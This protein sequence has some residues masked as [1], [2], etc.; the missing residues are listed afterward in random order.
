MT[1]DIRSLAILLS[2][3]SLLQV[4]VL[5]VQY[6][7]NR[8]Q[9]GAGWWVVGTFLFALA[10]V[11]NYLR[12]IPPFQA[13]AIVL[14]NLLFY[15]ALSAIYVGVARFFGQKVQV[16]LVLGMGTIFVLVAIYFTVNDNLGVRRVNFS[17][18][19]ALL[20][21]LIGWSLWRCRQR[22]LLL[23][24]RILALVFFANVVFYAVRGLTPFFVDTV[25]EIFTASLTQTASY[26]NGLI[27]STVWTFG[28]IILINQQLNAEINQ[29][30]ANLERIFNTSPDAV[31][32]SRLTDGVLVRVNDG[33]TALCGY[34]RSEAIGKSALEINIWRD[35]A[36]RQRMTELLHATGVCDNLEL[37]FQRKDGSQFTGIVSAKLITLH[38]MP[39]IISVTRDITERK[40]AEDALRKSEEKFRAMA[41]LLPQIIFETD[42]QGRLTYVNRQAYV[43]FG[44]PENV[45]MVGTLSLAFHVPE[46]RDRV[47]ANIQR[48]SRGEPVDDIEYTML[49]RD[50]STFPALVFSTPIV[51]DGK[52][53]GLRGIIVDIT[54]RKQTE[55][56]LRNTNA[57]LENL[58]DYAN[59]PIIVWD[60]RLRITRFNHAFE[61]LTGYRE[62]EMLGR[63]PELLFPPAEV[64]T[65]MAQIRQTS[66]GKRW[67]TVEI[68]ILH[69]NGAVRTVLWNSATVFATDGVTPVAT[70][71]QGQDIT[72]RKQAEDAV[73]AAEARYARAVRGTSDGLW[74]WNIQT[75]AAYYSPRYREL[76]GY[77]SA[78]FVADIGDFYAIVHPDDLAH[79]EAVER[80]H[81]EERVP[82]NVELRMRTQHGDYRWFQSRAQAEWDAEGNALH[83]AG[84]ITDISQ[85][86]RTEA[87]LLVA[88]EQAEAANRAKS[89][90]LAN[91][92]HELRTPLN[93]ILGF[94]ELL[95]RDARLTAEQQHNL[96]IINRSG[97]HL[98]RLINDVL[99]MAKIESG[100][101]SVQEREFDLHRLIGEMGDLF[102]IRAAEK[103]LTLEVTLA[104]GTPAAVVADEGKL[105]QMLINLLGNAFKFT[106][107]GGVALAVTAAADERGAYWLRFAVRDTGPGIPSEDLAAIFEPFVQV[108]HG[109]QVQ[110]GTGLGLPISRQFARLMGGDITVTSAGPPHQGSEFVLE[111]PV[112]T[113]ESDASPPLPS[114][115]PPQRLAP[116]QPAYRL[117]IVEDRAESRKLLGDL[118]TR[119]GFAVCAAENGKQ[120]LRLWSEWQPHL[121]WMDMRMP[122]MDG[123]AAV[124][125]IRAAGDIS[126]IIIAISASVLPEERAAVIAEGCNDFVGKPYREQEIVDCLVRHLGVQMMALPGAEGSSAAVISPLE[127]AG[128]SAAWRGQVAQ[129][130]VAADVAEL[131]RL[132]D[133]AA[134][135]Q[136]QVAA[137]LRNWIN[138]YDYGAI[139]AAVAAN[140]EH[141]YAA[142]ER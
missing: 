42:L 94:S 27:L 82:Y 63:S 96:T 31:V 69:C 74:D 34:T 115:L 49:R 128:M 79:V 125:H 66:T 89:D 132:A 46:E 136:P 64:A 80:A 111:V 32:I 130:A 65:S 18:A 22:P 122:V 97:E 124:R 14:N 23:T 103:G 120:A 78:E 92:S 87:A 59:A 85:R 39:H 29:A 98:L 43:T 51:Q 10:F 52:P 2:L 100:R 44:Y 142:N 127:L 133:G 54:E 93:A 71:A 102:S 67:K 109:Y 73:R 38:D 68:R 123:R 75:G 1:I 4:I 134:A 8:H 17:V 104:P 47:I 45:S 13:G 129:A 86:K 131:H 107:A 140:E 76:L 101:A 57:Y 9:P 81:L 6:R 114:S 135:T 84:S 117:L 37:T 30:N 3:A 116:G 24:A 7:L 26:L 5:A 138:L 88:K 108:V 110:E 90:F 35:E 40:L 58:I 19:L 77:A 62:D 70:I 61:Q 50:G 36:D 141:D 60:P 16:K 113:A 139:L 106:D 33:F 11:A 83:L 105:R 56:A 48:R 91:M 55:E 126:T 137:S 99:D 112:R 21:L 20:C 12:D 118:L 119:M 53:A 28:F 25:G 41:A 95:S 72:E 15:A 121:I